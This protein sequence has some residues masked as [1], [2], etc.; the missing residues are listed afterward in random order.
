MS[1]RVSTLGV[2][3]LTASIVGGSLRAADTIGI[4]ACDDFLAKYEICM[5]QKASAAQQSAFKTQVDETRKTWSDLAKDPG[6][7][8][9]L[10]ASC[11][12]TAEQIKKS[13]RALGCAF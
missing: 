6:T 9:A 12:Q 1:R 2:P 5:N 13:L 4:P 10:E 3:V 11:R 8:P 7:R